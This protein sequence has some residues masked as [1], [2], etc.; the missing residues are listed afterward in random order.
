MD[1]HLRGAARAIGVGV[2]PGCCPPGAS[3][4]GGGG[5]RRRRLPK[6]GEG[7][8]HGD[9]ANEGGGVGGRWEERRLEIVAG[10]CHHP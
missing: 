5:E 9:A 2:D 1:G 3:P 7:P 10:C 8:E 4:D 6:L